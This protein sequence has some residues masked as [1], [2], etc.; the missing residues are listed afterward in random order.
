MADEQGTETTLQENLENPQSDETISQEDGK[1]QLTEE[2]F[3]EKAIEEETKKHVKDDDPAGFQKRI[4]QVVRQMRNQERARQKAEKASAEKEA[5]VEEMRKHN[6]RLYKAIQRQ[7]NVLETSVES[8]QEKD[9]Q[10]AINNEITGIQQRIAHVKNQ[11]IQARTDMDW[12][13]DAVLEDQLD[14]LKEQLYAKRQ[15]AGQKKQPK[16]KDDRYEQTVINNWIS[17]T[18]WFS[19]FTADGEANPDYNEDMADYARGKDKRMMD[20]PKW[21]GV[22]IEKRLAEVRK[23]TEDH[24]KALEKQHGLTK[25]PSPESGKDLNPPK[26]DNVIQLTEE[27]KVIAHKTAPNLPPAEAEKRYAE[28]LRFINGGR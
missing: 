14:Q 22:P 6:E 20:S 21:A 17:D 18:P 23:L 7:T 19:E 2:Q 24:F 13:R 3:E 26:K 1:E 27:M 8:Q 16:A 28:Q 15:E 9:S 25:I 4:N 5:L 11:R 12:Q 10:S